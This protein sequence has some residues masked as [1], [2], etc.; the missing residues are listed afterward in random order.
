MTAVIRRYNMLPQKLI[1]QPVF[2][3]WLNRNIEE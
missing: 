3:F 1:A 2:S